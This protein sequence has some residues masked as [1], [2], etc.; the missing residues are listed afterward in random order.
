[1]TSRYPIPKEEI[2]VE[3]VV[4]NS[5]FLCSVAEAGTV[6]AATAFIRRVKSE[7]ADASSHAH[8]YHVGFGAS[9]TDGCND[10]GEPSGTAGRPML[11]VLQG[12]GLG[13]VVA[14][15]SRYFGGTKLGTGG[16]VRAFGGAL[17]AALEVLP[18]TERVERR[19]FL[20][21]IPYP[22]YERVRLLVQAHRGE[23]TAAEFGAEVMLTAVFVID[24]IAPATRALADLSAGKLQMHQID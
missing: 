12:S 21:E 1:M 9:V 11:A 20:I 4:V 18:R 8:A 7:L 6:D 15:V 10:G 19:T 14:V 23:I 2:R 13:D 3:T 5:R 22:L 24:D 16:L 17:K